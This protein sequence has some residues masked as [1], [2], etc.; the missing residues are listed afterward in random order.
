MNNDNV[1]RYRIVYKKQGA[2]RFCGHLDMQRLWERALRRSEV[3]VL[4]S[5]G[6]S[7][8]IRLNLASA[9]PL[10]YISSYELMDFWTGELRELVLLL[11]TLQSNIPKDL[12]ITD[13]SIVDNSLP[14]LQSSVISSEF[15][16]SFP[17]TFSLEEIRSKVNR[18]NELTSIIRTKR[19]KEYDL[20]PLIERLD[21]TIKES[22]P[23]L[24]IL[25]SARPGATGRP[26]EL[27]DVMGINSFECVIERT[28]LFLQQ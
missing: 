11:H 3:P 8:K 27:L 15:L 24:L 26:D 14:S 22:L 1:T 5:Q 6:F 2:L 10:G 16:I 21:L 23:K 20:L 17:A 7:P 28:K 25:M 18:V 12:I 9:L 4:Y 13:V 19:G